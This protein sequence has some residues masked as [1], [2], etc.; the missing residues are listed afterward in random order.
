MKN[1]DRKDSVVKNSIKSNL[2]SDLNTCKGKML[3]GNNFNIYNNYKVFDISED[4]ENRLLYLSKQREKYEKM[5]TQ[6]PEGNLLVTSMKNKSFFR[7]YNR[8]TPQDKRGD[9]L[10]KNDRLLKE[11]LALRKYLVSA[12]NNMAKEESKLQKIRQLHVDDSLI[13]TYSGMNPGVKR[14]I[15][16]EVVDDETYIKS[17]VSIA[18]EGLGFD[19]NDKTEY[20]SNN[21]ERMRSKSEVSIANLLLQE[22]IPYK[23]ECPIVRHNGAKLY[24]DFTILDVKRR[25]IV[26]W[27]HLGRMGD[28]SYVSKNLWKIDEYKKLGIFLGINLYITCESEFAPMGTNE[29]KRIVKEILK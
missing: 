8:K 21:G 12:L 19:E 10:G 20:Y 1:N 14:L 25:R 5:L 9:Y 28:M 26:Y 4:I 6:L 22:G 11:Q 15:N 27:E 3:I 29:P 18:Y 24:P 7:Y 13:A 16:P 17:W 2:A 23:Y